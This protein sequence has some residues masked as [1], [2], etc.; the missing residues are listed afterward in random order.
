MSTLAPF[1]FL[2]VWLWPLQYVGNYPHRSEIHGTNI[3]AQLGF[4]GP[5]SHID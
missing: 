1:Y 4:S 2:L 5:L 3:M